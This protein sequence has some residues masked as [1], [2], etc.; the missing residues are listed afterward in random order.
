MTG[1]GLLLNEPAQLRMPSSEPSIST[2]CDADLQNLAEVAP[3]SVG[4]GPQMLPRR[5]QGLTPAWLLT[6]AALRLGR[7][8]V[9]G[10]PN[11]PPYGMLGGRGPITRYGCRPVGACGRGWT[12]RPGAGAAWLLTGAALR[13]GI[14]RWWVSAVVRG[15]APHGSWMPPLSRLVRGTVPVGSD[16]YTLRPCTP[17][18]P[19]CRSCSTT[20]SSSGDSAGTAGRGRQ[21]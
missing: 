7:W 18:S 14:G 13:L 3:A 11:H 6:S 1:R 17:S 5:A 15:L 19:F 20:G 8:W 21:R 12:A 2:R 9:S 10:G 16:R 4:C